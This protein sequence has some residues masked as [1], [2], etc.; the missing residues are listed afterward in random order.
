MLL[1]FSSDIKEI[2]LE[3]TSSS[4]FSTLFAC[5]QYMLICC[6][7]FMVLILSW[8]NVPDPE[9]A[10]YFVKTFIIHSYI[11]QDIVTLRLIRNFFPYIFLFQFF[12]T[13]NIHAVLNR[14]WIFQGINWQDLKRILPS[15]C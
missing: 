14:N 4:L 11:S 10:L 1:R 12:S 9:T 7:H 13:F 15:S 6:R 3:L 5:C 2:F 8:D